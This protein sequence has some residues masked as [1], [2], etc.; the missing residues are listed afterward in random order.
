MLGYGGGNTKEWI[1]PMKNDNPEKTVLAEGKYFRF[2]L[3]G[4]WEYIEP[5][6]FTGVVLIVPLTDDGKLVLIEQYRPPVEAQVIEIPAGLVGD[7]E[8]N[9]H[10]SFAETA[11]RELLEETGYEAARMD[12]LTEGAPSPG[13]NSII[14]SI[15]G[16]TGLKKIAPGGGDHTEDITIHEVPLG[17]VPAWLEEKRRKGAVIDLKV[18]TGLH[19]ANNQIAI[20]E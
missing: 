2:V 8:D 7:L 20:G 10:E 6:N 5:K 18:Y 11:R 13:S 16:A 17:D 12:L 3:K 15:F 9:K 19:F 14:L 4:R 1:N